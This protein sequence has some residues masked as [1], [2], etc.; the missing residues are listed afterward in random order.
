MTETNHLY[1]YIR[2]LIGAFR[3]DS[4][5]D[6]DAISLSL[7]DFRKVLD[8][9]HSRNNKAPADGLDEHRELFSH[10]TTCFYG[11]VDDL[12]QFIEDPEESL[13]DSAEEL[14]RQGNQALTELLTKA[15]QSLDDLSTYS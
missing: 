13:L 2:D 6:Y 11:S 7:A 10:I 3:E 9:L 4:D 14:A 5:L 1:R 12:E 15:Q 8:Q